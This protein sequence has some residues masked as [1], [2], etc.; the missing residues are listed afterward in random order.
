MH[1]NDRQSKGSSFDSPQGFAMLCNLHFWLF[2]LIPI[3]N[4]LD[5]WK[6]TSVNI[7]TICKGSNT[8]VGKKSSRS[9]ELAIDMLFKGYSIS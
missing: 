5:V 2:A 4:G 3:N 1:L 8:K 7:A 9:I 6:G